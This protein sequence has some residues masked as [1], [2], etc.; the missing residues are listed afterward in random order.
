M[1]IVQGLILITDLAED[2]LAAVLDAANFAC[3]CVDLDVR[4]S[5][6]FGRINGGAAFLPEQFRCAK[7]VELLQRS[8]DLR[9]QV[10]LMFALCQRLELSIDDTQVALETV[11]NAFGIRDLVAQRP[12]LLR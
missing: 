7:F 5:Q 4:L 10:V 6:V 8:A 9:E 3:E 1:Q 11:Q 12:F 2:C